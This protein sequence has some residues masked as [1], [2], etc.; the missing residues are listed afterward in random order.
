MTKIIFV[1]ADGKSQ[2]IELTSGD[3][4]ME[5][6]TKNAVPGIVAECGGGCSCATCHVYLS[7]EIAAIVDEPDELESE[8]LEETAVE[9]KN[10]S[11]LSC[12][13]SVTDDMDGFKVYIP[14]RQN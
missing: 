12:Q 11:R 4:L 14:E 10:T 8:M 2:E 1:Q 6:A 13:I 5:G 3:T 9:R 7:N